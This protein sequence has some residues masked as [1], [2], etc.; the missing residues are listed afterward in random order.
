M[1][2]VKLDSSIDY[3]QYKHKK[4][5]KSHRNRE[6]FFSKLEKCEDKGVLDLLSNMSKERLTR[7]ILNKLKG[8]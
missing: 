8:N 6:K 5:E 1:E 7:R 2:V 4:P 3:M